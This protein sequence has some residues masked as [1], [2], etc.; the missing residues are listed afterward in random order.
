MGKQVKGKKSVDEAFDIAGRLLEAAVDVLRPVL[1][2]GQHKNGSYRALDNLDAEQL[3]EWK[4]RLA[5]LNEIDGLRSEAK[6][7]EL[8]N[9]RI[10]QSPTRDP[11]RKPKAI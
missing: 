3:Q 9:T 1:A 10:K 7:N 4:D 11:R 2:R 5:R 6:I 8:L